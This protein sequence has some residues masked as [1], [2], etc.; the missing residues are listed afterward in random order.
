MTQQITDVIAV[1]SKLKL[2]LGSE[3]VTQ[4]QIEVA[5]MKAGFSFDRHFHLDKKNIPDFL[6]QENGIAIEVKL[7]GAKMAIYKQCERYCEFEIVKTL[8]LVS[9]RNMKLPA[10][11]K[12]CHLIHI[13]KGWL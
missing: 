4:I 3:A 13:G 11:I 1:I 9:N 5:L 6:D 7:S 12:G 10:K 2:N 8:L